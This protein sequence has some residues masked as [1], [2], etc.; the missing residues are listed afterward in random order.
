MELIADVKTEAW[1]PGSEPVGLL[2][3]SP[4]N[5]S[6]TDFESLLAETPLDGLTCQLLAQLL[7]EVLRID[8]ASVNV[9]DRKVNGE[10]LH[11]MKEF[12]EFVQLSF[13]DKKKVEK[14][15]T[16]RKSHEKFKEY[17]VNVLGGDL[18][19]AERACTLLENYAGSNLEEHL[20]FRV[21]SSQRT[22]MRAIVR[23]FP[24]LGTWPGGPDAKIWI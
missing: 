21:Q 11:D 13:P 20:W 6:V 15:V 7:E 3:Q 9:K 18:E 4:Y 16:G 8:G 17:L 1:K 24:E 10:A 2:R 23:R 14:W 5:G 22:N 19:R 12:Q